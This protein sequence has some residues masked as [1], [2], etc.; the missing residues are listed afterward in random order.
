MDVRTAIGIVFVVLL[1]LAFSLVWY[2]LHDESPCQ[3]WSESM[4][5][6]REAGDRC[7]L[8]FDGG[9]TWIRDENWLKDHNPDSIM[10]RFK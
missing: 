4:A 7:E 3:R 6:M 2:G 10:E 1:A 9:H 8:S 5:M